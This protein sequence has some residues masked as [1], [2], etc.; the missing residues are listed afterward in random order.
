MEEGKM[1]GVK[2]G[3]APEQL[4]RERKNSRRLA[5]PRRPV[6]EHVWELLL[7]F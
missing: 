6:E 7:A 2:E 4:P 3:D 1:C 5:R